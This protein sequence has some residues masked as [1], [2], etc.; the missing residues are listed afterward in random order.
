MLII[1]DDAQVWEA[2]QK[3]VDSMREQCADLIPKISVCTGCAVC[4][5]NAMTAAELIAQADEQLYEQKEIF[6]GK[7][8]KSGE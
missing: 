2:I 6:H 3:E 4:T 1:S 5:S 7:K 8:D